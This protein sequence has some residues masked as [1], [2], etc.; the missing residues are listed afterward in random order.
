MLDLL[1]SRGIDI[2]VIEVFKQKPFPKIVIGN[3]TI[4]NCILTNPDN[5]TVIS[6]L[7]LFADYPE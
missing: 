4:D 6:S 3:L 7:H 2:T 1:F 5:A